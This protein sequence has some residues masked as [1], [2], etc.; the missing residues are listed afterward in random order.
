MKLPEAEN[1]VV[2]IA[3]LRDYC[4]STTHPRGR[5]KARVF[6]SALG[7]TDAH[8]EELRELLLQAARA[9]EA[10]VLSKDRFGVRYQIDVALTPGVSR[11]IIR[12]Y[13]IVRSGERV[14]RL[15][16]CFVI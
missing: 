9:N 1:A 7:M 10:T 13:W 5:H 8:A 11:S 15:V 16:T 6:L 4:L 12:S 14:P 3:K 2:E